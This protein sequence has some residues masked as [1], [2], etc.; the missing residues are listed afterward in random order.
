MFLGEY[1]NH[2]QDQVY[3]LY[4]T[5]KTIKATTT[6]RSHFQ[7][8]VYSVHIHVISESGQSWKNQ[9]HGNF[10]GSIYIHVITYILLS[11]SFGSAG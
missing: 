6:R 1:S 7:H 8:L 10:E 3:I 11:G 4:A 9:S 2:M 5:I